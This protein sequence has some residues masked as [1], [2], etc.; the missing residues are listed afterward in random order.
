MIFR[1]LFEPVSSTYT[2][3]LADPVTKQAVLID[4]VLEHADRYVDLLDELGLTLTHTFET[5]VHADHVT[6]G[7]A[8]RSRLGS[9][10]VVHADA[11]ADCA[12]HLV[13]HGDLVEVGA[14][15]FEIRETPGHTSGCVSYLLPD[16]VFTGDALLIAGCGRTD[17]QQGDAGTLYDSVHR[18]LF[19]LPPDTLVYPAHDYKG[20]TV[21]TVAEERATNPRL[22]GDRTRDAFIELMD[23]LHLAYP[24]QIDRAVPANQAC[25]RETNG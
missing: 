5:H 2:Y 4:P 3:L 20:R 7:G 11:G 24:K 12:D 8:L 10:T 19:S 25:G 9:T 14:L 13:R 6:A 1:Q 17:F 21:T 23:N 18:E 22:G 15:R 16:R